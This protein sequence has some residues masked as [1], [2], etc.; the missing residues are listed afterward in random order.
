MR[1]NK[2]DI[3]AD[4]YGYSI[5]TSKDILECMKKGCLDS[6]SI[7]CN[8]AKF[9][10]SMEMLYEAIP[11][12]PFLPLLSVHINLPEGKGEILPLS[13]ASLFIK[14]YSFNKTKIKQE[15]K[16][17]IKQQILT[18]TS[19]VDKC[20]DI[21]KNNGVEC[22][23]NGI[24][25]DTHIHT[26]PIPIVWKSLI[27]VINEEKLNVEYIRN[28]KE[29]LIPFIKHFSLIPSYGLVNIIKNRILMLYS[30]KIDTYCKKHN[31]E[32]MYMWGLCMSGHMDSDRIKKVYPDMFKYAKRHNR[33]LELLFHPGMA[34]ED[35]YSS[36]MNL[37]YFKNANLSKNR[38]IEKDAVLR[39]EEIVR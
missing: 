6:V 2:V 18:V 8:N 38:H 27:E 28:P 21:A 9:E 13:W 39:I 1:T 33:N 4:D 24:R 16:Q 35:E 11:S 29:P 20:I 32:K 7:I 10:E 3:H 12:L 5:N 31:L 30:F 26:H 37:E 19:V 22:H 23:Q 34:S 36:E 17:E 14:S 25:L 15:I